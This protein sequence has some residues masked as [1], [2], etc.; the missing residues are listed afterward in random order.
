[1][2]AHL[3]RL[4]LTLLANG[5]RRSVWQVVGLVLA[6]LYAAG[7]VVVVLIGLAVLSGQD[8]GLRRT[9][10][11]LAGAVLV[12]AWW[13]L[14]LVAFG[15]DATMEPDRFATF[16]VPR[17]QLV[18]GLAIGALIGVPGVATTLVAAGTGLTWWREPHA[19]LAA[20]L[21]GL[22]AV[23]LCVVGS[24]ATATALAPVMARRRF[25]EVATVVV[26]VPLIL[27][28]PLLG[29]IGTAL[30]ASAAALPRLAG[31]VAWTPFGAP[32]A[33]AADAA[34]GAWVEAIGR[35]G[36]IAA[37][38][39]ALLALW[40][41]SLDRAMVRQRTSSGHSGRAGLG[42][43][44][45]VPAS[46]G[47]AVAA[48]CL[49]YW[50]RD[51]RYAVAVVVIPLLPVLLWFLGGGDGLLVLGPITAT[52]I[53]WSISSDVS[54]DGTA[55]ALHVAAPV[56]GR[57]DR[58]GRVAAAAAIGLPATVVMV[59]V[60][61]AGSG[62]WEL[63][64]P[65]LGLSIGALGSALGAASVLSAQL[66][67]PVLPPGSNP[68]ATPQGGTTATMLSQLAGFAVLGLLLVPGG[69]LTL[70]AVGTG[71]AALGLL[72]TAVSVGV[73]TAALVLGVRLGGDLLDRRG[74]TLLASL[75]AMS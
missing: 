30:E 10:V 16:A 24:R 57:V 42:V 15:I 6:L 59:V 37:S 56:R 52:L 72:S 39:A 40:A 41:A 44:G 73:G 34:S 28:G 64:L 8:Q 69:V 54:Y 14:P 49:V 62:R 4:K 36:V 32:W 67:Y 46:A 65:M 35:L 38:L 43:L 75:R 58:L 31:V 47:W 66:V 74:T 12:A 60:G 25:R 18:A 20:V 13:F 51:P 45:R 23:A 70:V 29:S 27:A 26:L 5:L 7:I 48:R 71:S 19:A 53:G 11:V 50:L 63:T 17:R 55:F 33:L 1:M 61:L 2:V 22:L 3:V 68:F 21:G 9:V